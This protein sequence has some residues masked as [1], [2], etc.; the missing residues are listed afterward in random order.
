[1]LGRKTL[2]IIGAGA[3]ADISMPMGGA[4]ATKISEYLNLSPEINWDW[5]EGEKSRDTGNNITRAAM[6]L[7]ATGNPGGDINSYYVAGHQ[8][9][10]GLP[11]WSNSIDNY[12]NRHQDQPL[13]QQCGKLAI[14]QIILESECECNL[15][16]DL[17]APH[18]LQFRDTNVVR[19][20]WFQS[21]WSILETG[22]VKSKNLDSIFDRLSVVTFNYDRTFEHFLH[23]GLQQA[24]HISP[25]DAAI[26]LN[27]KL[28]IDHVY[29]RVADLPWQA[30]GRGYAFGRKP[31]PHDLAVLWNR[32]TTFNEEISD[33]QLLDKLALKVG[34]AERIIFLGCHFHEQ[35]MKLL[36]AAATASD[37][38]DVVVYAT[39]T[40]RSSS[41][42]EQIRKQIKESIRSYKLELQIGNWDCRNLF[43][44]FD[45]TWAHT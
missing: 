4:L 3:G 11:G 15:Y 19:H 13:V 35:N 36:R 21:L 18:K 30:D 34:D 33:K 17:D 22:I 25:S 39:A 12:L 40:A 16:V 8:I 27:S 29:G 45:T 1:M 6:Q 41:A 7:L 38:R 24:F 28:D 42:V 2:L 10:Q 43:A 23:V 5:T 26:L 20:S 31:T 32:I 9:S 44:E 14:A 37:Q